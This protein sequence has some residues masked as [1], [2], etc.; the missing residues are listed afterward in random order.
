MKAIHYDLEGDILTVTFGK[1]GS[2]KNTG[3]ELTDNIVIYYEPETELPLQL[4]LIGYRAMRK[5][6]TRRAIPLT[7]LSRL[8]DARRDLILRLLR[9][10]PVAYFL[11]LVENGHR[12][13]VAGRL[14]DIFVPDALRA[15]A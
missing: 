9:R 4:I 11:R 5:A 14:G 6:S 8:P 13:R 15:V 10:L 3:V 12:A 1:S 2:R 7:G